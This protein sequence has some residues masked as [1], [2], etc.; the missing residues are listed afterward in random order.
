[1]HFLFGKN[2][3]CETQMCYSS[4]NIS[5]TLLKVLVYFRIDINTR[6]AIHFSQLV[7][8]DTYCRLHTFRLQQVVR[9]FPYNNSPF[10]ICVF[11]FGNNVSQQLS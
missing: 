4:I 8:N 9:L 6:M 2:D 1:M 10:T 11:D 5:T 3:L 7:M